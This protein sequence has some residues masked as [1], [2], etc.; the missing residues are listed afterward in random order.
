V[1]CSLSLQIYGVITEDNASQCSSLRLYF[2]VV[3]FIS[4][5]TLIEAILVRGDLEQRGKVGN[6]Y[7]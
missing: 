5:M 4:C 2:K 7:T 6:I 3:S 1:L